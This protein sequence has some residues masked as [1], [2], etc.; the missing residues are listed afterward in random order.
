[1]AESNGQ[2]FIGFEE[3]GR[4]G[5]RRFGGEVFEEFLPFLRGERGIKIFKEMK[6]NDP[7]IGSMLFAFEFLSRQVPWRIE[8]VSEDNDDKER[9]EFISS[10][11]LDDMESHWNDTLSEIFTML[12]FGW[13]WMEIVYKRRGGDTLD[14]TKKSKFD[15]QAIGWRKWALRGQESLESWIFK[16]DTDDLLGMRQRLFDSA[17]LVE[18]P[19][20]K[21][22][23]F[24]T[25]VEKNNPEGRS[26]LRNAYR[27]WYFSKKMEE[28]EAIGVERDLAGLPM[29]T[30][31]ESV[32]IWNP[33]DAGAVLRKGNAEKL[34]RSIRRDEQEG[35]VKPFGWTLEL[36]STG[37]RRQMDI[38][39][40]L[41]RYDQRKAMVMLAD[42]IL[43]GH[44][45][46]GSF[47]LASSKTALFSVALGGILDIVAEVVNREA[48]PQ[49]AKFNNWPKEAKLP[50]LKHGDI[51]SVDL[52]ALGG[53]ITALSGAGIDLTDEATERVLR[54]QAK[55]PIPEPVEEGEEKTD[56]DEANAQLMAEL[57]DMR[58]QIAAL[59]NGNRPNGNRRSPSLEE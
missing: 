2:K 24:R 3:V 33:N 30:P 12:P 51:E 40:I 13:A 5:L 27:P 54:E 1:M 56:E 34:V 26:L 46:V 31:P 45:A 50:R 4:G 32:D 29:L 14:L 21:S 23:L 55:L 39:G 7:V 38:S 25:K 36:L 28:I 11:L 17:K 49:L 43:L 16:P 20:T 35:I 57:K 18:I 47:A 41:N 37:G 19:L 6:E 10:A 58:E 53:Y 22:L 59:N 48:I 8:P 15:D 42:F 44:E 9:A 52:A